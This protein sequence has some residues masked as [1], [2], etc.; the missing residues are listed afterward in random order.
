MPYRTHAEYLRRIFRDNDLAEG[1]FRAAGRPVALS[2]IRTPTFAM[3]TETDH[4]APWWSVYKLHL[5]SDAE[6]TFVLTSGGHNAGIV[7]EPGHSHRHYRIGLRQA[8]YDDPE[9]WTVAAPV[10]NGSWWPEWAAWLHAGPARPAAA[11]AGRDRARALT[12]ALG[13]YVLQT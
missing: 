8:G 1:R 3:G 5:L 9:A 7:S 10:R 13:I 4:V 6:I 11:R 2:D 12:D